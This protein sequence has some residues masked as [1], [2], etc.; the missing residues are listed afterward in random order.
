MHLVDEMQDDRDALIVDA[1]ILAQ[2]ANELSPRKVDVIEHEL[3]LGLRRDQPAGGDPGLEGSMLH[4]AA[5]QEFLNGDHVTPPGAG[6]GFAP[7]PPASVARTLRSPDRPGPA[8]RSSASRIRRRGSCRRAV[9]PFPAVAAPCRYWRPWARSCV[10][11]RSGSAH[12]ASLRARLPAGSR[13]IPDGCRRP[14]A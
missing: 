4:A 13:A 12:R 14:C 3:G 10:P 11:D 7:C 8:E 9:R 5:K 1:E 6:G 2:I